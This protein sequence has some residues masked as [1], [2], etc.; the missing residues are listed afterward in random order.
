MKALKILLIFAL[1]LSVALPSAPAKDMP[2]A[3]PADREK[4]AAEISS[5]LEMG[6]KEWQDAVTIDDIE[7]DGSRG[8]LAPGN[9]K[10]PVFSAGKVVGLM[11]RKGVSP[12]YVDCVKVV[13]KAVEEGMRSWQ[14]TYTHKN[15]PFP[16]GVSCVYTLPP[17]NNVPVTV[18]SGKSAGERAMT[19]RALYNYMRYNSSCDDPEA[20]RVFRAAAK[21]ISEAFADWKRSCSIVGIL[22]SGGIAPA[23][24]PMGTGPG[25]VRAAKGQHGKFIG[26]YLD[27]EKMRERMVEYLGEKEDRK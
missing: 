23:P 8:V 13:A 12:E 7:V 4:F 10:G 11:E 14:R 24:A 1:L 25:P 2:F 15:I 6:W 20:L 19:E 9:I 21:A 26:A 22:A 3:T 5:L 17:C 18:D 27:G 16:Q